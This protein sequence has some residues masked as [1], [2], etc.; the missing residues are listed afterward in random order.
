MCYAN[1]SDLLVL[2][3][4]FNPGCISLLIRLHQNFIKTVF[5]ANVYIR[6]ITYNEYSFLNR[7]YRWQWTFAY[8]DKV[9]F[10]IPPPLILSLEFW[11]CLQLYKQCQKR[12]KRDC[13]KRSCLH[14]FVKKIV[15]IDLT[16]FTLNKQLILNLSTKWKKILTSTAKSRLII[17]IQIINTILNNNIF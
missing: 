7:S 16:L 5:A 4:R 6:Q 2:L 9:L 14:C 11:F 17:F 3:E 1:L 13:V 15:H 8:G 10:C 12:L